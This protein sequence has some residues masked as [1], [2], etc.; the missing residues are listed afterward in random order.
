MTCDELR[1][2]LAAVPVEQRLRAAFA[3]T[4]RSQYDAGRRIGLS[5]PTISQIATGKREAS[6]AE[7]RGLARFFGLD[8][9]ELFG[10][11]TPES[12]VA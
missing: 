3:L 11:T 9:V 5:Q 2:A 6:E 4:G 8:V 7:R 1:T 10:A 12:E